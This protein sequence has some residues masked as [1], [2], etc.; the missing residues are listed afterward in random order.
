METAR[1]KEVVSGAEGRRALKPGRRGRRRGPLPGVCRPARRDPE[2]LAGPEVREARSPAAE[3]LPAASRDQ[4]PP[5]GGSKEECAFAQPSTSSRTTEKEGKKRK[6]SKKDDNVASHKEK[7]ER[8]ENPKPRKKIPI[9][10]IP[11]TLPPIDL[12]HRDILRAWG[13]ELRIST[14]GPKIDLYRRVCEYAFPHQKEIP[15]T[16]KEVKI[17]TPSQIKAKMEKEE[18]S[19]ENGTTV[20][21]AGTE[22]LEAAPPLLEGVPVPLE[23]VNTVEVTTSAPEAVLASWARIVANSGKRKAVET[24]PE[25]SGERWCVVHGRSLPASKRGWVQLQFHAGQAWVP[26]KRKGRVNALFLLPSCNFPPSHLEDNLLC[27][28]CVHR[29]KI[30][31]RSLQWD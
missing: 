11:T 8:S 3:Q 26:E 2:D 15:T 29:N 6:R 20:Y 13:Q 27:P 9:P 22:A 31:S 12:V 14:K 4:K 5:T 30:L 7:A 18:L 19:L 24:L 16:A 1:G 25:A 21:P 28:E 23:D 17:K 10:P